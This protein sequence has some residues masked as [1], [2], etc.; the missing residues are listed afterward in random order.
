MRVSRNDA[1]RHFRHK[2][3]QKKPESDVKIFSQGARHYLHPSLS[4][5]DRIDCDLTYYKKDKIIVLSY[6]PGDEAVND[7]D[8][9][10]KTYRKCA[11]S[12]EVDFI[13]D[14]VREYIDDV[15]KEQEVYNNS[16]N[17]NVQSEPIDITTED[18]A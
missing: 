5:L 15:R 18:I 12:G 16:I 11:M 7:T 13:V 10:R 8:Y 2:G 1:H 14:I 17:S 9:V 3:F 4:I 6:D